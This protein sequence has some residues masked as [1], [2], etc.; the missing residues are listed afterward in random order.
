MDG[1]AVT[2]LLGFSPSG[3]T[4]EFCNCVSEL[5]TVKNQNFDTENK[6]A[7]FKSVQVD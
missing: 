2:A 4:V 6:R 7:V 3:N 5:A 1:A